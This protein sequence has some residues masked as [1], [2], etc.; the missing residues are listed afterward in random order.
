LQDF[1]LA[2]WLRFKSLVTGVPVDKEMF[3]QSFMSIKMDATNQVKKNHKQLCSLINKLRMN[4]D[5]EE[6]NCQDHL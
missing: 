6:Y 3:E 1:S 2:L 4:L 5:S